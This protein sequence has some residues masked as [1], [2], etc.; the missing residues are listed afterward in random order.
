MQRFYNRLDPFYGIIE[1]SLDATFDQIAA[2]C[3]A[4]IPEVRRK[5]VFEY[6]CGL[7]LSAPEEGTAILSRLLGVAGEGVMIV[8]HKRRWNPM[9][10][11]I[12]WIEGSHYDTFVKTDFRGVAEH[13]GAKTFEEKLIQKCSVMIFRK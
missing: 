3:I 7:Y 12:E 13:I 6:A 5:S 1:K 2:D 8:D 10:A 4:T 9:S 11:L